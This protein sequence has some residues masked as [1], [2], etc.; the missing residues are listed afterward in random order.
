MSE[1][2]TLVNFNFYGLNLRLQ[3][4]D[5][6]VVEKIRREFSYF[7][8][9]CDT[10]QVNIE[11]FDMIPPYESLPDL[12]ASIYTP[13]NVCYHGNAGI[14][15]DYFGNALEIFDPKTKNCKIF[16]KNPEL[17]REVSYLSILSIV[18]QFLD[19]YHIHRVHA[20]G[21]SKNGKAILVLLPMGGGKSTLAL[22]LLQSG[23]VKLLSDDSPLITRRGE[24]LPFPLSIGVRPGNEPNIPARYL[25]W[26]NRMNFGPKVL[27]DTDYFATRVSPP[28]QA[29]VI[30]LGQ[31]ALGHESR[32]EPASKLAA[33]KAFIRDA[34]IG[35]G[36]FKG[37]EYVLQRSAWEILGKSG[38]AFSRLQ[39]SLKVIQRSK[40]HRYI[41]GHDHIRNRD[42]LLDF[43]QQLNL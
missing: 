27:I 24:V 2:R 34:V 6:E 28:C 5:K 7:E 21:I 9:E 43:V 35:L 20:L 41:I 14:F 12:P 26:V 10:P 11:V 29:G 31:R 4:T 40:I 30:L 16:S 3:S 17:R 23:Q 25:H 36:L 38:V 13:R 42:V 33:T 8:A 19:A 15:I 1:K 22:Q 37:A 39:S 18:S 32:I